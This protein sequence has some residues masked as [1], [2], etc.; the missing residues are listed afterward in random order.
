[1]E[2]D[3]L[4]VQ[5]LSNDHIANGSIVIRYFK[6]VYLVHKIITIVESLL[7]IHGENMLL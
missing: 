7:L 3:V 1:M 5:L 2:L 4:S 6:I